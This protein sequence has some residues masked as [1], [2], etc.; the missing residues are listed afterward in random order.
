MNDITRP[1]TQDLAKGYRR[2]QAIMYVIACGR[3]I[4][5][6]DGIQAMRAKARSISTSQ[7]DIEIM[8]ILMHQ[9]PEYWE[10]EPAD[11]GGFHLLLLSSV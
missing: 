2:F 1:S 7:R 9:E 10:Q 3:K 11:T 4:G 6:Y 5:I 8:E